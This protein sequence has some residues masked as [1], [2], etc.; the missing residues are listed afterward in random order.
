VIRR[1]WDLKRRRDEIW[2][3]VTG[4]SWGLWIKGRVEGGRVMGGILKWQ[5]NLDSQPLSK[6]I[7][8]HLKN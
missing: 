4:E 5:Q 7:N 2:E 1:G 3:G 6:I 8:N